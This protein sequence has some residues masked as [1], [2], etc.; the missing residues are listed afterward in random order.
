MVGLVEVR[1]VARGYGGRRCLSVGLTPWL[2]A[3]VV[4][5]N[6]AIISGPTMYDMDADMRP[7]VVRAREVSSRCL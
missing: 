6:G 4:H 2:C 1:R 5:H 3:P 7:E